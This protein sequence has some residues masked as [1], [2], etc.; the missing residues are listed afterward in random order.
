M[1]EMLNT[2]VLDGLTDEIGA[3]LVVKL[4]TT[5]RNDIDV[6]LQVIGGLM[7]KRDLE[8]VCGHAHRIKASS[9]TVGM[10]NLAQCAEKLELATRD[11]KTALARQIALELPQ[12]TL[13]TLAAA[14]AFLARAAEA[15]TKTR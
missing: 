5:V 4:L 13:A 6:T 7:V 14:D 11:G 15:R 1:A 2:G 9:Q 3:E 10:E 8:A 12:V